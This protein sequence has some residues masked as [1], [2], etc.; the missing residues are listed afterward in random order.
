ME[1]EICG[2]L[3]SFIIN[4]SLQISI[5]KEHRRDF[6]EILTQSHEIVHQVC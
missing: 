2:P 3:S 1:K 5:N 4:K 6:D